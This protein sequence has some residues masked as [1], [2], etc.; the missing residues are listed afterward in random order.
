MYY[1]MWG[2]QHMYFILYMYSMLKTVNQ[3]PD[4]I[5]YLEGVCVIIQ[6]WINVIVK[7][8]VLTNATSGVLW[9][10]GSTALSNSGSSS[11]FVPQVKGASF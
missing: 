9:K 5:Y 10:L 3:E 1:E 7:I 6:P 4:Q 2:I 11:V 8:V